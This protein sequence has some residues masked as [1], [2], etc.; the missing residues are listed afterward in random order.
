MD[1]RSLSRDTGL[2]VILLLGRC[3]RQLRKSCASARIV[4]SQVE[5]VFILEYHF[6]LKLFAAARAVFSSACPDKEVQNKTE[7]HRRVIKCQ[8][9][10]NI[11]PWQVFIEPKAAEVTMLPISNSA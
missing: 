10:G 1:V 3:S 6:A 11:R 7:I 2:R 5:R 9:T 4:Y 8:H